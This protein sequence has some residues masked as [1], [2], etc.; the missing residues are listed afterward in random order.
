MHVPSPWFLSSQILAALDSSAPG[1][2]YFVVHLLS[3]HNCSQQQGGSH[4]VGGR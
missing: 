3:F 4:I 1:K 2:I